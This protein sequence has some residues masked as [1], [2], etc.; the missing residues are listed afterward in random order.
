MSE[1]LKLLNNG[2]CSVR[3]RAIRYLF[4]TQAVAAHCSAIQLDLV[5]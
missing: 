1:E 4:N 3:V 5:A 2:S